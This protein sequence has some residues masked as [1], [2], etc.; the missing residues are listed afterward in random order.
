MTRNFIPRDWFTRI[1]FESLDIRIGS[2]PPPQHDKGFRLCF[3]ASLYSCTSVIEIER[4]APELFATTGTA[5]LAIGRYIMI[6]T[7]DAIC[8][9]I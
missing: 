4:A 7:I 2:F 9:T 5:G 6:A 3:K 1:D 8:C